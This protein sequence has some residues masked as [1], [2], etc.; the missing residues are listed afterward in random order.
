MTGD[1]DE[2]A[3]VVGQR[4]VERQ[5][6]AL[7]ARQSLEPLFERAVQRR[8][9]RARVAGRRPVRARSGAVPRPV[10]EVLVLQLAQAS[11][12]HGRAGDE[13]DRERRLHTSRSCRADRERRCRRG[14]NRAA[15]RSDRSRVANHAGAAPKTMPVTSASAE[16]EAEH[17]RRRRGADRQKR[18][19]VKP[20]DSNSRAAPTATKSPATP[21]TSE[22][23]TL[24]TSACADDLSPGRTD[25]EPD[26]RLAAPRHRARQQQVR[27]VRAGDQQ[28]QAAHGEQDLEASLYCSFITPTPRAGG[29]D[30]DDLLRQRARITSGIQFAG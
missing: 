27:D 7:H 5:A 2:L 14:P 18:G 30:V 3:P 6:G 20:S 11:P 4:V 1:Q 13:H 21:P 22:S 16:R 10:A 17:Q 12:Q 24:S 28:H 29:H 15:R 23:R 26:R 25:R 9:L 19:V 8:Q